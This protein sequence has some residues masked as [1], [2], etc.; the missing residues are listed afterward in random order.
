M[1]GHVMRGHFTPRCPESG[2]DF[3]TAW[4]PELRIPVLIVITLFFMWMHPAIANAVKH[5]VWAVV[6]PFA[7]II[8]WATVGMVRFL[9]FLFIDG[10]KMITM[11][12]TPD[13]REDVD[14][15]GFDV[16]SIA[17]LNAIWSR[18]HNEEDQYVPGGVFDKKYKPFLLSSK[19]KLSGGR[20]RKALARN[21]GISC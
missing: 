8:G 19:M 18:L 17:K 11:L 2:M 21:R 15:L 7:L 20:Q 16:K 13:T 5:V 9:I 6:K 14:F 1:C 3:T 10:P 12:L 4:A